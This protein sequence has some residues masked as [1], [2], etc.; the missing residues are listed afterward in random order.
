[1]LNSIV[2]KPIKMTTTDY[3]YYAENNYFS[4]V[5]KHIDYFQNKG[6]LFRAKSIIIYN[7]CRKFG[8]NW[9]M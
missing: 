6:G 2:Q 5:R 1:M 9:N 7:P 3:K 4:R 8:W